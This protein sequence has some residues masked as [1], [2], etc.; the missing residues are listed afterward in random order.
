MRTV[1]IEWE[2]RLS[3]DEVEVLEDEGCGLYQIYGRH[4]IFGK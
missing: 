3:L 1:R 4:I 2:G